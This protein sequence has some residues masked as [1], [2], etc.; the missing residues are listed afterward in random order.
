[1]W[2]INGDE[3]DRYQRHRATR[4]SALVVILRTRFA[5]PPKCAVAPM[6]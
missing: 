4:P 5:L 6:R 1:M 3:K 2:G